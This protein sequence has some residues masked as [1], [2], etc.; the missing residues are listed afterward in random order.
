MPMYSFICPRCGHSKEIFRPMREADKS[1]PCDGEHACKKSL[2]QRDFAADLFHTASDSYKTPIV[3]DSLA[4]SVDQIE[5]H[6]QVFPDVKIT[7]QGQPVMESYS[8]HEKYLKKVGF[9]KSPQKKRRQGAK[10]ITTQS[11]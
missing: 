8:Q 6:K 7:D 11:V 5:E 9:I 3:S 4:V 10:K 2:M 1:V